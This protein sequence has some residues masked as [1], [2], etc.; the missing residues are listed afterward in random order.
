MAPKRVR[1]YKSAGIQTLL[2]RI[3]EERRLLEKGVQWAQPLGTCWR[4][5]WWWLVGWWGWCD[6]GADSSARVITSRQRQGRI[7]SA[8]RTEVHLIATIRFS[9]THFLPINA[10]LG[11]TKAS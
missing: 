9:R 7:R 5:G 3:P 8:E 11:R 4:L 10:D 2:G 1:T 6:R